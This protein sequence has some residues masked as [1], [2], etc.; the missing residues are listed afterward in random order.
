[1]PASLHSDGVRVQPEMPFGILSE[2][3]FGFAGILKLDG[4]RQPA[5]LAFLKSVIR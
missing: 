3:A 2:S 5:E 1:M 4:K